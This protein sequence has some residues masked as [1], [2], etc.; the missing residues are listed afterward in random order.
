MEGRRDGLVQLA[1]VEVTSSV[2]AHERVCLV[3]LRPADEADET[4]EE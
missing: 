1:F 3:L 4:R 2:L